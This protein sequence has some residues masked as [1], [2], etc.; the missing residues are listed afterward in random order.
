MVHCQCKFVDEHPAG[1]VIKH[2]QIVDINPLQ[3]IFN[4]ST[5]YQTVHM[6][7]ACYVATG[8]AVAVVYA[9]ACLRGKRSE[10]SRKGLLVGMLMAVIAIP[11]QIISGDFN[12][13][14]LA[15]YQPIKFAA[16]QGVFHTEQGAH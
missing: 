8:F 1:F 5:P 3:A 11:L 14:Y 6:I 9:L 13:R 16:M 15:N 7:L 12:A 10:Y 4:P 2:G